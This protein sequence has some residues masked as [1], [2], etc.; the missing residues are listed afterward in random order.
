VRGLRALKIAGALEAV[1]AAVFWVARLTLGT[2]P[3][4]NDRP[5][6]TCPDLSPAGGQVVEVLTVVTLILGL[7]VFVFASAL[8]IVRVRRRERVPALVT[9]VGLET[10]VLT[11]LTLLGW[12]SA[13]FC[14]F[15]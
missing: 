3:N 10:V 11:V 12:A 9:L 4:Y 14:G 5:G 13:A 8:W 15:N 6:S 7:A 1:V 2:K